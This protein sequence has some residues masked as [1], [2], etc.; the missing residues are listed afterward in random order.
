METASEFAQRFEVPSTTVQ[1]LGKD[2]T[3]PTLRIIILLLFLM[4]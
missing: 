3:V 2:H 1:R 4:V